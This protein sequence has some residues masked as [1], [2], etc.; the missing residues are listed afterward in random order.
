[1]SQKK[2]FLRK[3][4]ICYCTVDVNK[5]LKQNRL[6]ISLHNCVS[7]SKLPSN[8]RTMYSIFVFSFPSAGSVWHS[9]LLWVDRPAQTNILGD[10]EVTANIY[11][12]LRNLPNTDTQNEI[13]YRTIVQKIGQ[14]LNSQRCQM[15][16]GFTFLLYSNF[17]LYIPNILVQV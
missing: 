14:M 6:K 15:E 17:F 12:Q 2:Q 5:C 11:C 10:P 16:K 1:M 8:I 3:D 13:L 9:L 7:Y 4:Q